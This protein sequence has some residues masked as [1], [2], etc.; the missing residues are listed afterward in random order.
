MITS[1]IIQ[2]GLSA[3]G[4]LTALVV[5]IWQIRLARQMK[6]FEIRQ[7]FR[8][9]QH[10]EDVIFAEATRFIQKYSKSG[11]DSEIYLLPLC[12]V[13]YAYNP[14][15]PYRREL[16]REFCGLTE[17][18]QNVIL[19]RYELSVVSKRISGFYDDMLKRIMTTIRENYPGDQDIF[20]DN[21]KYFERALL[22]HGESIIPDLR[23]P[24]DAD[25]LE[26]RKHSIVQSF[27][28]DFDMSY[29]SHI[30]NLLAWH[31]M[32]QPIKSLL[33]GPTN[34]GSPAAGDE[35]VISYLCCSVAEYAT[36]YNLDEPDDFNSGYV[37]DFCGKQYMEDMFLQA[38]Y[39]VMICTETKRVRI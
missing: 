11:H 6:N 22:H 38:L 13:A 15:Y 18:V 32:E 2:I 10:N 5:G 33:H 16:Y 28:R 14:V 4:A 21:G 23:C 17:D 19:Q 29:K 20:Y 8:D 27:K 25:E 9:K 31:K 24:L 34:M 39:E 36:V 30:T 26:S 12:V 3:V 37:C 35:I 1:E 7:D